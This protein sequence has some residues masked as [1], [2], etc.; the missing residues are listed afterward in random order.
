[1]IS[2]KLIFTGCL[3]ASLL[4]FCNCGRDKIEA[5]SPEEALA[6][7]REKGNSETILNFYTDETVSLMKKYMKITGMKSETSV[8]ILSF[9]PEGAEY[10]ITGKKIEGEKCFLNIV[11]TRHSSENAMGQVVAVRMV[12]DGKSWKIDRTDDFKKLIDSYEKKG[13]E[14][15]LNKIK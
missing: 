6:F 10:N 14:N 7:V 12:K 13:I 15:Y 4:V 9:I 3:M 5:G 1:M 11:F 8:D 2:Y